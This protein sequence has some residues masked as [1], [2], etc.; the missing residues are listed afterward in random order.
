MTLKDAID[1][2]KPV[3]IATSWETS[4]RRSHRAEMLEKEFY[5][6]H[7]REIMRLKEDVCGIGQGLV[8][9]LL[10]LRLKDEP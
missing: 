7:P 8:D 2:V 4:I 6:I 5:S 10:K 3:N 9:R 1:K